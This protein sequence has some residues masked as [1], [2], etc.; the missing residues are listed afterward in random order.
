MHKAF[1]DF[2]A[3]KFSHCY[4]CGKRNPNGHQL[5]S[6]WDGDETVGR[7]SP[8]PEYS[9]G[10]PDHVYGGLIA[11]LFDCHGA[12][13]A[14]AFTY[15][16]LNREM[17]SDEEPIRYVTASLKVDFRRPTPMGTELTIKGKL[18]SIEGRKVWVDLT[19]F[20][21][22]EVCASGEMLAIRYQQ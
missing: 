7:H 4:G 11:S 8:S 16:A 14:A 21:H 12:A 17:K 19:L 6:F 9:G 13:S 10:V 3:E 15:R 2:Y 18:R 1:Q 5:K 22:G 20:A